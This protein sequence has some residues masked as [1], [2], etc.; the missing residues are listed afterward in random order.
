MP[1]HEFKCKKC[2][3]VFEYLCM[4]SDDREHVICPDCGC[5]E[6]EIQLSTFSSSRSSGNSGG[7]STSCS[8]SRG[9]S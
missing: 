3:N 9:F 6:A 1:I 5:H 4:R 2:G 7:E 8:S